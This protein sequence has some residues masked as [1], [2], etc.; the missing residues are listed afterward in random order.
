MTC[1]VEDQSSKIGE[2][3]DSE[4]DREHQK[5]LNNPTEPFVDEQF[6]TANNECAPIDPRT[7][8]PTNPIDWRPMPRG[9]NYILDG[10]SM[11]DV[12]QGDVGNCWMLASVAACASPN[13]RKVFN[14]CLNFD[15]NNRTTPEQGFYFSFYK[16]NKWHTVR[17]STIE[18]KYD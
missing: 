12:N 18:R 14:H 10:F 17:V 7:G 3:E 2:I 11:F 5:Q 16:L 15:K 6:I 8:R 9:S 4:T 1:H 13:A